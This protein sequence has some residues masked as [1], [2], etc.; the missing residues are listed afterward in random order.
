M[1]STCPACG[2]QLG[3]D[4]PPISRYEPFEANN[5]SNVVAN[6][7][8][9]QSEKSTA[10][11]R[12]PSDHEPERP[13]LQVDH[14]VQYNDIGGYHIHSESWHGPFQFDKE[15]HTALQKGPGKGVMRGITHDGETVF[16]VL[17]VLRT[18]ITADQHRLSFEKEKILE[19]GILGNP[20]ISVSVMYTSLT[21]MS[22]LFI[23]AL[24]SVV[25]YDTRDQL[26]GGSLELR[27]PFALIGHHLEQLEAKYGTTGTDN[28][29]DG[30]VAT[31]GEQDDDVLIR[32]TR[33]HTKL[34]LDFVKPI[35]EDPIKEEIARYQKDTPMC[36]YRM[37]W[38]LF[39]P[40]ITV[41]VMSDESA[42]AYMLSSVNLDGFH[43][44]AAE[45]SIPTYTLTLWHLDF[46]GQNITRARSDRS[47]QPFKGERPIASL[48]MVPSEVWDKID[49]GKLR[50]ELEARGRKWV[51]HLLGKQC[52][53]RGAPPRPGVSSVSEA[54]SLVSCG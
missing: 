40:G 24:K 54:L 8:D 35:L 4:A 28:A 51:D 53:Y 20:Q 30:T 38:Y 39:R 37:L 50:S 5:R 32:E 15:R 47:I 11:G 34:I 1:I 45:G 46:D 2:E 44:S 18:S 21:I 49:N 22:R 43:L 14:A 10:S 41:Y 48:N 13:G 19:N 16:R 29:G 9:A 25:Q 6:A 26:E 7:Y 27:E 31:T 12:L 36:T 33:A 3:Q 17:T 23:D 42:D 52:D